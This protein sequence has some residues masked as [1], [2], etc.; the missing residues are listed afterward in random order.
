MYELFDFYFD[1]IKMNNTRKI[2]ENIDVKSRYNLLLRKEK[3]SHYI[4]KSL[5][6]QIYYIQWELTE[7][8]NW[9]DNNNVENIREEIL[10][11]VYNTA[12]LLQSLFKKWVIDENLIKNSAKIQYKKILKRQPQ[13][14]EQ[15]KC[16]NQEEEDLFFYRN[17]W[18]KND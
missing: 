9:I 17:K 15:F 3:Y 7:L 2:I 10:D 11:I 13:L 4:D 18:R 5:E 8:L 14:Q 12:Q 1:S 16:I 6:E